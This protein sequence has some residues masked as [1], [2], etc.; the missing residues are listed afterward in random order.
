MIQI[1]D[2]LIELYNMCANDLGCLLPEMMVERQDN[3]DGTTT[4]TFTPMLKGESPDE[5]RIGSG[6]R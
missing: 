4:W 6:G 2:V 1:S 5:P 3:P